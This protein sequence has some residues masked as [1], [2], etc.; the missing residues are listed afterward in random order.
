MKW[1]SQEN[2]CIIHCHRKL[3]GKI[4][5]NKASIDQIRISKNSICKAKSKIISQ[6]N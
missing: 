3:R 6:I 2:R 4:K 1:G 5:L